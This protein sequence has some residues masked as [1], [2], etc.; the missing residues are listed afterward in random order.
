[1]TLLARFD[2]A[3]GGLAADA[4]LYGLA[5][6]FALVTALTS[7]LLP[8]RAW[9]A[10]AAWAYLAAF[11]VVLVQLVL[12]RPRWRMAL[13]WVAWAALMFQI[14][15]RLMPGPATRTSL[16]ELMRTIGFAASPGLFQVFAAFPRMTMP[17]MVVCWL[18]TFA[19]TVVAVRQALDYESTPRTLVVSAGAAALCVVVAL[20]IGFFFGPT[21]S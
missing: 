7:T 8:H 15:A 3:L 16:T 1:M 21:L 4:A 14:G 5:A 11:L 6:A 13:T 19:A 12:R 2:R 10:V 18:W 20:V 9:G 17:V